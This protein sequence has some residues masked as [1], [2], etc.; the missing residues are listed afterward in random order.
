MKRL[1]MFTSPAISH[2]AVSDPFLR[3]RMDANRASTIPSS[4]RKCRETGRI[5]AFRLDWKP[6][7]PNE[8]HVFWDS[9]VAKVVEGMALEL[10]RMKTEDARAGRA[11]G[12]AAAA[13]ER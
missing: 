11:P 8:P 7:M 9:D 10:I 13:L 12:E 5:D 2:V 4:L 6:G 1:P 3:P